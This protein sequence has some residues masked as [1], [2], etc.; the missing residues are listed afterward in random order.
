MGLLNNS[1]GKDNMKEITDY[2]LK[3]REIQNENSDINN[4]VDSNSSQ[5]I[6]S[7][8]SNSSNNSLCLLEARGELENND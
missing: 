6:R 1:N 7:K 4:I 3:N 5:N 2:I 8:S